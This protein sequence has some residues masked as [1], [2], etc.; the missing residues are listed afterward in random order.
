VIRWGSRGPTVGVD[1]P[2]DEADEQDPNAYYNRLGRSMY[3]TGALFD[4]FGEEVA[5]KRWKR[6]PQVDWN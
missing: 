1:V 5:D 4:F 2:I 3:F 6:V